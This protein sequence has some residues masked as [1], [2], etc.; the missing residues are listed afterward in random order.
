MKTIVKKLRNE[1]VRKIYQM[2]L[3][4]HSIDHEYKAAVTNY[5]NNLPAL[6]ADD[7]KLVETLNNDGIVITSL[8][9]ISIPLTQEMLL[10]AK[11]LMPKISKSI[12]ANKNEFAL[13]AT[14][15]Q[16]I[17]HSHIF[18]WGLQQ[19]L[20]NIAENYLSLP[21]AYHGAYFRRDISNQVQKKSRLW[22]LDKEDIRMMKIIVYLNEINEDC[23]PFQYIPK[24]FTSSIFKSLNY[25][26]KYLTDETMAKAISPSNWQSCIGAFGTVI[27]ADTASIFHKGKVPVSS[28]RF[29]IFYDYTSR[30]PK[31]PFYCKSSLSDDALYAISTSIPEHQKQ[32]VFWRKNYHPQGIIAN[33]ALGKT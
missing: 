32:Y 6:S 23:G 11:S 7:S 9:N 19:R 26:Y 15:E 27:I 14:S 1:I 25:D 12:S 16:I 29:A 3:I 21:V 30:Q 2:P 31:H 28:D 10:S 13:H 17:E 20:L 33:L 24:S 5:A 8:E 22:H 4:S 18:L